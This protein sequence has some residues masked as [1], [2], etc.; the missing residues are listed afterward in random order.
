MKG[1]PS[2]RQDRLRGGKAGIEAVARRND[3]ARNVQPGE[4]RRVGVDYRGRQGRN[5]AGTADNEH[6]SL[7]CIVVESADTGNEAARVG[8]IDIVRTG[9]D[10]ASRQPVVPALVGPRGIDQQSGL[11]LQEIGARDRRRIH[12]G[13]DNAGATL[14]GKSARRL[15]GTFQRAPRDDQLEPRL[16]RQPL[17]N[18]RPERAVGAQHD[19]ALHRGVA[20]ISPLPCRGR[21]HAAVETCRRLVQ[22]GDLVFPADAVDRCLHHVLL[23]LEA[24][25]GDGS[26][27]RLKA[28]PSRGLARPSISTALLPRK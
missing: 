19:N 21:P 11:Y 3:D 4:L 23:G 24:G 15:A 7:F 25:G 12:D 5:R 17:G 6:A 1:R 14:P 9:R 20:A 22:T 18:A 2:V 16:P 10:A 26:C 13:G 8:K 28:C 27:R